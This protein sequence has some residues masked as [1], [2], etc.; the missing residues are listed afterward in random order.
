VIGEP[1]PALVRNGL[2]VL[3]I[4]DELTIKVFKNP[5]LDETVKV[6]PDG[7]ISVVLLADI[8]AAG[9]T[10][11][12]ITDVLLKRYAELIIEPQVSVILRNF[13]N[14]KV[15][16]GGEVGQP[17]MVP[18]H[19]PLTIASAVFHAGG[20]KGSARTDAVMLVRNNGQNQPLVQS[21]NL[22]DVLQKGKPD[23]LLQPFDVVYVPESRIRRIDRFVDEYI[24]QL[25]PINVTAG[26]SY[27][28]G[29]T[30]VVV[31]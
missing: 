9:L 27:L 22:K 14:L 29:S 19:G 8:H 21:I 26:F 7:K 4:G 11:Q 15:F 18:L 20:L 10:T 13:A 24:R 25:I 23:M 5:E 17:G 1:A 3:Q 2:Y 6:R 30:A 16:V 31:P 12:E 28:L